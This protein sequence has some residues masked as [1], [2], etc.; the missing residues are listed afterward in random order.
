MAE[1]R[2]PRWIILL[3]KP[4]KKTR[5]VELYRAEDFGSR[6]YT[7]FRIRRDG[8]WFPP[9]ERRYFTKTQVKEMFFRKI[10]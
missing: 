1:K 3:K 8:K 10:R 6:E 5:K 2:K 4:G 9:G 7:R